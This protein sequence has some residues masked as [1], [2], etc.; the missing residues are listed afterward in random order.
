[1]K[2]SST[3]PRISRLNFPIRNSS[4]ARIIPKTVL[5][6]SA[7]AVKM[8]EFCRV[9]KKIELVRSRWKFSRPTK[10]PVSPTRASLK[11]SQTDSA[12]G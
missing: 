1:M 12:K 4:R 6:L 9:W 8:M 3:A 10:E 2:G 11:L 5:A 7:S